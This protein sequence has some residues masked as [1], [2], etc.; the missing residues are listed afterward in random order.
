MFAYL[1]TYTT[2]NGSI[3]HEIYSPLYTNYGLWD[4]RKT[5]QK[6]EEFYRNE[7]PDLEDFNVELL[8]QIDITRL[9]KEGRFIN[10]IMIHL[11]EE[12]NNIKLSIQ[13]EYD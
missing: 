7:H 1:I 5:E 4:R 11:L 2:M 8:Y 13:E 10:D 6:M 3:K 9:L 12:V